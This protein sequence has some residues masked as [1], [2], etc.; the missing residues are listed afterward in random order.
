VAQGIN[1]AAYARQTIINNS[2]S[3]IPAKHFVVKCFCF[4]AA[5]AANFKKYYGAGL[6]THD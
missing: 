6:F 4:I 3:G 1:M 2:W 5:F